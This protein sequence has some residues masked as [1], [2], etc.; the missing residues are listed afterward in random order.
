MNEEAEGASKSGLGIK[1]LIVVAIMIIAAVGGIL[2]MNS[3]MEPDINPNEISAT[4]VI[5][6]GNGTIEWHNVTTVNNSVPGLLDEAIGSENYS[7][8]RW[9]NGVEYIQSIRGINEEG[10]WEGILSV[11]K[12]WKY[13]LNE[14]QTPNTNEAFENRGDFTLIKDEQ[15]VKLVFETGGGPSGIF[16]DTGISLT[17]KINYGNGTVLE[18]TIITQNFT[19]LGALEEM[20]GYENL[21]ITDYDWGVLINGINNITTGSI[22]SGIDDTSNYYWMWYVNDDFA[23]VGASQYVLQDGDVMEWSFEE[24]TW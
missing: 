10:E 24:S 6:Y 11:D 20:V 13:Y 7:R 23:M 14:T 8:A 22:V 2:V 18:K 16:S 15:I 17:V 4:L 19:A 21:D 9:L 1:P 5:D 12:V 3:L